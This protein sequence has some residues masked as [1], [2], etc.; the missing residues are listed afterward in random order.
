[1]PNPLN[2][3]LYR[4][5]NRLFGNVRIANE[6]LAA[7]PRIIPDGDDGSRIIFLQEGEYYRV[8]CPYCTD[9]R[10]RLY[11]NHLWGQRM[12]GRNLLFLA[13][14]FNSNCLSKDTN[15]QDFVD[16]MYD[17]EEQQ[18]PIKKGVLLPE[19]LRTVMLP[20]PCTPLHKLPDTHPA[21]A[22][23]ISRGF[24]PDTLSKKFKVSYCKES[25]YFMAKHR[26]IIPVYDAGLL[27][28]WQG[29]YIGELDWKGA[30]KNTARPKYYNC[31]N[32][33][34][35]S[36]C[37]LNFDEMKRWQTGIIVE[38]PTDVFAMGSMSCCAFGNTL[39][40][41]QRKKLCAVF[42]DAPRSLVLLL[43]PDQ[44]G[45]RGEHLALE[46]FSSRMRGRFCSVTLPEGTDPGSLDRVFLRNYVRARAREQGVKVV[47]R[48]YK[49]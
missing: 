14:C 19:E 10:Y 3:I 44:K 33:H 34:F 20:G 5:L 4:R 49:E 8:S 26:I 13:H 36:Q 15:Y 22:Y 6:G 42:E 11:V 41:A 23:L 7:E 2:S 39:T 30:D 16:R 18:I 31:P 37:L 25:N 48:V 1:M 28:G 24:D 29:R 45:S 12:C 43:D 38:G 47:Y 35:R 40:D 27:K 21:N 17:P 32:S 9:T 46:W